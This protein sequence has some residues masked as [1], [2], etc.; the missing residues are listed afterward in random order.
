MMLTTQAWAQNVAKIGT[1][2]YGS[3]AEAFAAVQN[4]ETIQLLANNQIDAE[5]VVPTGKSFTLDLGGHILTATSSNGINFANNTTANSSLTIQNGT[6]NG[7]CGNAALRLG[8][9][10][11]TL[12]IAATATINN[13]GG[14]CTIALMQDQVTSPGANI[15]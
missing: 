12:T 2:E 8:G 11:N 3:L 10:G 15:C 6:I 7:T 1:T 14:N 13:T 9:Q 5:L 4:D